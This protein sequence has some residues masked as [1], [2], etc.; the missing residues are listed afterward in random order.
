MGCSSV[1]PPPAAADWG[2]AVPHS[3]CVS[4]AFVLSLGVNAGG[5]ALMGRDGLGALNG[6]C[7][8]VTVLLTLVLP[9]V[10]AGA[11]APVL[12]ALRL[13]EKPLPLASRPFAPSLGEPT[14]A[15]I[16]RMYCRCTGG[17]TICTRC[18][19]GG[20]DCTRSCC[21]P[22][23]GASVACLSPEAGAALLEEDTAEAAAD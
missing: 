22:T 13:A 6:R 11:H 16:G 4:G 12:P 20:A 15:D 23:A 5:G 3:V 18:T 2:R 21:W 7:G 8:T 1:L 14:D 17:G 19:P 9:A 10:V